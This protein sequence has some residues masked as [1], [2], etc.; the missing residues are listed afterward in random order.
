MKN[1]RV[2]FPL[3]VGV[4]TGVLYSLPNVEIITG[5]SLAY[6]LA[7]LAFMGAFFLKLRLRVPVVI[8]ALLVT[9]A[10]EFTI[11]AKMSYDMMFSISSHNLFGLE[12]MLSA[13][14]IFVASLAGGFAGSWM[15]TF[16]NKNAR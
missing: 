14:I 10:A 4:L 5:I 1:A 11:I 3:L 12:I 6:R 9:I 8:L 15:L 16:Q 2:L 7:A 13:F